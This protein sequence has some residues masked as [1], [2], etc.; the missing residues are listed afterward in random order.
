MLTCTEPIGTREGT[1]A[2]ALDV[3]GVGDG[4]DEGAAELD[5]AAEGVVDDEA[6]DEAAGEEDGEGEGE[7]GAL[8]APG[9]SVLLLG[10]ELGL[11]VVLGLGL[12]RGHRCALPRALP[13]PSST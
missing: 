4:D 9:G 11:E 1:W 13:L 3:D 5:G 8:L 12:G 2:G 7:A 6:A 10:V